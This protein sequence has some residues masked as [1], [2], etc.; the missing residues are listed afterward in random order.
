MMAWNKP[1]MLGGEP[2]HFIKII[3][4]IVYAGI[5][6]MRQIGIG[7]FLGAYHLGGFGQGQWVVI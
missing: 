1:Q 3:L 5:G 6:Q 4:K 7:K 2:A